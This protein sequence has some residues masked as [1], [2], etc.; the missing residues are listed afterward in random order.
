[1][2]ESLEKNEVDFALVSVLPDK[3]QIESIELMQNK[4]YLVG[5]FEKINNPDQ[6]SHEILE[7]LPII[8]REEGSGTRYTFE[9][10]LSLNNLKVRKKMQLTSNEAV[11]QA[12]IAGLGYSVMPL[13]GI[14][15]ELSNGE[16]SIIPIKGFP[17]S[18]VWNIIWLKNKRFSPVASAF[19][20]N[21]KKD[22][23]KIIH[24][25]FTW[26]ENFTAKEKV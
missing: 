24:E 12:V 23:E 17:L 7:S 11:K 16:L 5:G 3:L 26:F 9:K 6:N 8:Y 10:Y 13:I 22:K 18:S 14:K 21:L 4:L 20:E 19:L 25:K 2:I 15:N 1:V